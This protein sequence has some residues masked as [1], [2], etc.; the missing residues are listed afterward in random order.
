MKTSL[1]RLLR[2]KFPEKSLR[3]FSKN[4]KLKNVRKNRYGP[5]KK[6][7][8]TEK[9]PQK[10]LQR[11]HHRAHKNAR[12][13]EREREREKIVLKLYQDTQI[14]GSRSGFGYSATRISRSRNSEFIQRMHIWYK[15]DQKIFMI[16]AEKSI[17][18]ELNGGEYWILKFFFFNNTCTNSAVFQD[19]EEELKLYFLLRKQ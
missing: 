11:Q 13:R 8:K 15:N 2:E 7:G 17:F 14:F 10:A 18:K 4:E 9:C 1:A 6:R 16:S 12:E 5:S 3:L 19:Y